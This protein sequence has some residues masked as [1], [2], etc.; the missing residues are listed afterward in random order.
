MKKLL[1]A[2]AAVLALAGCTTTAPAADPTP[3]DSASPSSTPTAAPEP[4]VDE[5]VIT[6]AGLRLLDDG[7][8]LDALGWFDL[9]EESIAALTDAF[10]TEP[11]EVPYPGHIE[12]APGT[13]YKWDGF[14]FR[15]QDFEAEPPLW[16]NISVISSVSSVGDVAIRTGDGLTIGSPTSAVQALNPPI[17]NPYEHEGLSYTYFAVDQIEIESPS[18]H[19]FVG[20]RVEN[21]RGLVVELNAPSADYG[22]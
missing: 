13:D 10:G 3:S 22:V 7:T 6:S 8:E 4:E 17:A 15:V 12:A 5:I 11:E 21:D 19:N 1:L 9:A 14:V 16:S 20:V 2:A 18:T